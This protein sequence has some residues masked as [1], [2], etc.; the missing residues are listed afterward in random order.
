MGTK[1]DMRRRVK[2]KRIDDDQR[3]QA[4]DTA[5]WHIFVDGR[6]I[7]SEPVKQLL[8]DCSLTP[9]RVSF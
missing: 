9:T 5:R 2:L 8:D 6:P 3:Q 4:V 7:E 1:L